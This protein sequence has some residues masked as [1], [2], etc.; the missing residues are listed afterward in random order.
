MFNYW[1]ILAKYVL[2]TATEPSQ[3]L[4]SILANSAGQQSRHVS[5]IFAYFIDIHLLNHG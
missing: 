5:N 2:E 3:F 4:K 1:I